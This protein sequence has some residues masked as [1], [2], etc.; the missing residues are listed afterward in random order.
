MT[1]TATAEPTVKQVDFLFALYKDRAGITDVC[2][3]M[4]ALN[5][6]GQWDRKGVSND[7]D[8][9]LARDPQRRPIA[10]PLDDSPWPVVF[11]PKP[12]NPKWDTVK[13]GHYAIASFTG[14]N[15]LDFYRVDKP[16]EGK[17][18]GY[19]FVKRVIGGQ[20][21]V[22]IRKD[23]KVRVLEAIADDPD[24]GPRYGQEIGKCYRCNRHLT[25]ETSRSLGIG[26][27]CRKH[28]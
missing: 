12:L 17:W 20:P 18:A 8:R 16:T 14:N 11:A 26:P 13:E 7:I 28:I 23:E 24:A 25:D 19:T 9:L 15:D 1:K 3:I 5:A 2:H 10:L 22:N 4:D 6:A 27:E 21:D